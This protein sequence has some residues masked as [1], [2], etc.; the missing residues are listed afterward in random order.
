[1]VA[2]TP[3]ELLLITASSLSSNTWR[4]IG[5]AY[6]GVNGAEPYSKVAYLL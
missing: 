2:R 4:V 3:S 5:R 6:V 1:M